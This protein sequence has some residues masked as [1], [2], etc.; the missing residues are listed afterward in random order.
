[1]PNRHRVTHQ[2]FTFTRTSAS[3]HYSHAVVRSYS[4]AAQR[5]E[6]EAGARQNWTRN[7]AFHQG[8][9]AGKPGTFA[10][11]EEYQHSADTIAHSQAILEAGEAGLVAQALASFDRAHAKQKLAADGDTFWVCMGW[12]GREGLA[13]KLAKPGDV[14]VAVGG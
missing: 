8:V 12:C 7:L 14:I 10:N 3:R 1:M 9:V 11:G 6:C 5:A 13:R 4:L 2:G